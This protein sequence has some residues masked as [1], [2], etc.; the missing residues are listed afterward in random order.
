VTGTLEYAEERAPCL[1][2]NMPANVVCAG[3]MAGQ[4]AKAGGIGYGEETAPTLK[5]EAGGTNQVPTVVQYAVNFGSMSGC[6]QMN[7][8][9]AVT[10][11]ASDGGLGVGTGLYCL[12]VAAGYTPSS[13]A[14][15]AEGVG[16]LKANGGDLGGGSET[17]VA[18]L[19]VR[20]LTPLECERLQGFP[21]GWTRQ[22]HDGKIISDGA[23]YRA[24]GN[25]VAIP[26]VAYVMGNMA[27]VMEAR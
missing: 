18:G 22:G 25:S 17:L 20:K 8:S 5:A 15:Y 7:A 12:P 9:K 2:A 6:V 23:R 16:T 14:Q 10:L 11:N 1:Q 3:F 24:L 21:C 4:G 13:F 26:C 27:R 19:A